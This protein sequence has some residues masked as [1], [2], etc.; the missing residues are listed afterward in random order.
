MPYLPEASYLL[1]HPATM[2]KKFKKGG[3]IRNKKKPDDETVKIAEKIQFWEEQDR[4]NNMLIPRVIQQGKLL[5]KHIA[6]HD[7]MPHLFDKALN[8]AANKLSERYHSDL[9]TAVATARR[10]SFIA[11]AAALVALVCVVLTLW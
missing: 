11:L 6:E 4:L 1:H 3:K 9:A 5:S 8:D 7:N 2:I 10:A